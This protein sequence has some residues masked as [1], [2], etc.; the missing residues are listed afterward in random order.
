MPASPNVKL[1]C[2]LIVVLAQFSNTSNA[3]T[4]NTYNTVTDGTWTSNS[5]WQGGSAGR[6]A[7]TG[8]CDCTIYVNPGNRLTVNQ[9]VNLSNALIVLVGNG[10][11]LRF[12]SEI[13]FAQT[14]QLSG[15]SGIEIRNAG[16]NIQSTSNF[17][18]IN[19]NSISIN[20]TVVF[21]GYSTKFNSPTPGVVNGPAVVNAGMSPMVF[22]NMLLP[23][24]LI[25]FGAREQNGDVSLHWETA[26]EENF[27]RF[28]LERSMNTR[29]WLKVG[30][31]HGNATMRVDAAYTFTD[32]LPVNGVN[33]YRLKMIDKDEQF[34]Y[35]N[36]VVVSVATAQAQ[37]KVYPNPASSV[38]HISTIHA[39]TNQ[40]VEMINTS[41]QVVLSRKFLSAGN[42]IA[43]NV[44]AVRKG[45]YHL[46]LADASGF[47][48][49]CEVMIR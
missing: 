31:V 46:R 26:D 41:G 12:S 20:G 10:S 18:G 49:T 37:I 3:Q 17:F 28:E 43:L 21:Q 33:Y 42:V 48:Q 27:D 2:L 1:L 4:T 8:N 38:L 40:F 25:A 36:I 30:T 7:T 29:D 5:T 15:N 16:A 34:E 11:E 39:G 13:V 22:S 24:K 23:V 14:M 47:S 45:L 35:S 6:P 19:G 32:Q 44:G 9:N